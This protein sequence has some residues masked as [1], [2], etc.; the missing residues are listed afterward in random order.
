MEQPKSPAGKSS[1]KL[2]FATKKCPYC[3]T[4]L[5]LNDEACFSC[6]KKV[7][8]V[9]GY[10]IARKPFQWGAYLASILTLAALVVFMMWAFSG[11]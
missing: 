3:S 2:Q 4:P 10:G 8:E 5:S 7:G 11:R 6:K 9:D 1:S